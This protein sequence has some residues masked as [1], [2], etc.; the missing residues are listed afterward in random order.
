MYKAIQQGDIDA[1]MACCS[2]PET[3]IV[4]HKKDENGNV[5]KETVTNNHER[6]RD[7]MMAQT[8]TAN[9]K[10]L[11]SWTLKEEGDKVDPNSAKVKATVVFV[12]KDGKEETVNASFPMKRKGVWKING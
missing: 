2:V 11:K 12:N 3:L 1:A 5:E 8:A 10:Q 6:V 7:M 9:Y 4:K